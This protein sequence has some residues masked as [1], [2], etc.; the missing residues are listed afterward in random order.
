MKGSYYECTAY[1]DIHANF[2]E[3]LDYC[4]GD[5]EKLMCHLK[6]HILASLVHNDEVHGFR[7][8]DTEWLFDPQPEIFVSSQMMMKTV[9]MFIAVLMM[10]MSW[11][12][13]IL[14]S[15]VV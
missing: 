11:L 12:K 13:W 5:M 8:E 6:P 4:E 14:V 2:Q 7:D 15:S 10:R 1:H 9:V 3:S